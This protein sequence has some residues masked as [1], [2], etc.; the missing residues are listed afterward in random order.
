MSQSATTYEA[1]YAIDMDMTTRSI[2]KPVGN[3]N[4]W[5]RASLDKEHCIKRVVHY[6]PS[7]KD[8]HTCSKDT[9]TCEGPR[10]DKYLLRVYHDQHSDPGDNVPSECKLGDT[11]EIK[12]VGLPILSVTEIVI[13]TP[14]P[15]IG[16]LLNSLTLIYYSKYFPEAYPTV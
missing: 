13:T 2:A 10:C 1:K 7:I 11:V 12:A 9:C 6:Y 5:F 8:T 15:P 3:G 16:S 14:V 4:A